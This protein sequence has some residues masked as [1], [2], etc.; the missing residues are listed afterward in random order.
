ML[1]ASI[2]ILMMQMYVSVH[3]IIFFLD[4][5]SK[6]ASMFITLMSYLIHPLFLI[7][8]NEIC[9]VVSDTDNIKEVIGQSH[10]VESERF[11]S[12]V[13]TPATCLFLVNL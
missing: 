8:Y 11:K 6:Y 13:V 7:S 10:V 5:S 2:D 1:L 3:Q 12:K 4:I 9:L